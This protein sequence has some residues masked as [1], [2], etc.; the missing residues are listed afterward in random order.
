MDVEEQN[1][2]HFAHKDCVV[3]KQMSC[4]THTA[5]VSSVSSVNLGIFATFIPAW[6]HKGHHH[7]TINS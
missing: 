1:G 2:L 7:D 5:N 4:F 3:V 6:T